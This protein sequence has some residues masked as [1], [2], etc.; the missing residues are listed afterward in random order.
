[1]WI[2]TTDG[3]YSVVE[4]HNDP[5]C[6]WVRARVEGDLERLWPDADVL[7]TPEADYRYRAALGRQAVAAAVAKAVLGIG[8]GN[9]KDSIMDHRRSLFYVRIWAIMAEMQNALMVKRKS[10]RGSKA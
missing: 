4:D 6:L 5:D 2:Y 7:E 10:R 8:Y 1:M 9:F 3:F